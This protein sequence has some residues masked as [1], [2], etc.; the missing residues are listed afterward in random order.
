M[1]EYAKAFHNFYMERWKNYFVGGE[2]IKPVFRSLR[3][4]IIYYGLWVKNSLLIIFNWRA[5]N[6]I[7]FLFVF[8]RRWRWYGFLMTVRDVSRLLNNIL[9]VICSREGST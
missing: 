5:C 6:K 1:R 3:L 4:I 7:L 8:S 2:T 9:Q